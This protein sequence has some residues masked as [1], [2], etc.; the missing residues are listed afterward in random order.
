MAIIVAGKLIIKSGSRDEFVDKSCEAILLA[1]KNESC[2]DF[3]VSPDPIDLNRVNIFE[4]WKS[5]SA[6]D[7]F[8]KSGPE[9]NLFSLVE[10]F[11]VSEYELL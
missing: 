6:L 4:K 5:R 2:M 8:R 3:S 11:D 7:T 10:S 1:R 9:N